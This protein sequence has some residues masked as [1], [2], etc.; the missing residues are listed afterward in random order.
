MHGNWLR[1]RNPGCRY[2]THFGHVSKSRDHRCRAPRAAEPGQ[3]CPPDNGGDL[4]ARDRLGYQPPVWDSVD[5]DITQTR[6][7]TNLA[8]DPFEPGGG[9]AIV[10]V[11]GKHDRAI[12]IGEDA[13]RKGGG[14]NKREEYRTQFEVGAQGKDQEVRLE[15]RRAICHKR[16]FADDLRQMRADNDVDS[17]QHEALLRFGPA[18]SIFAHHMCSMD[19]PFPAYSLRAIR[20]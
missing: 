19:K 2:R 17:K 7:N 15:F 8:L 4:P 16:R 6:S 14:D 9:H 11:T 10:A 5:R 20:W 1:V 3:T 12:R 18:V 13:G